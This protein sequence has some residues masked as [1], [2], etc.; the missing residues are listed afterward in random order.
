MEYSYDGSRR[1]DQ[2]ANF[3]PPE[4]GP[5]EIEYLERIGSGCF[6]QVFRGRCRG[7]EVAIKKL[8]RQEIDPKM[9]SEFRKEV[10]I[11]TSLR[12]PNV[13]LL[14]GA[15]L[16]PGKMAL[17]MEMCH[18]GSL[19]SY[20]HDPKNNISMFRRLQMVRDTVLGMNW[21][22]CSQPLI[23]HRDLK[24]ANLLLDDNLH[25]RVCDFGLSAVKEPQDKLQDKDGIRGT[26]LWMAPE[27]LQ[28][29][30]LDEK[31]DVYSFAICLWEIVT[32]KEPFPHMDSFVRFKRA[33]CDKD[34]RPELTPD[35]PDHIQQ[36]LKLSWQKDPSKRPTFKQILEM[37][38]TGMVDYFVADQ[39]ANAFWKEHFSGQ[40]KVSWET[41]AGLFCRLLEIPF[42]KTSKD[43]E[44]IHVK[45]LRFLLAE[46]KAGDQELVVTLENFGHFCSWFSPIERSK[47]T[48]DRIEG[49]VRNN[50]FHGSI[51]KEDSETLLSSQPEGTF[52]IR[53]SSTSP[54]SFTISKKL[55]GRVIHQRI[56][57]KP[58]FGF[59]LKGTKHKQRNIPLRDFIRE[60]SPSLNLKSDCPGSKYSHVFVSNPDD[61][62]GY[63]MDDE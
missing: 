8:T 23:I 60:I 63:L 45:Y 14:M 44:Q 34:E 58:G 55:E 36:I 46:P 53:L 51:T 2:F 42:S 49:I 31:T 39:I 20:L 41:F 61:L 28:G 57:Y 29:K 26:P 40:I 5:D 7:V 22:H 16:T 59:T 12:H 50:W 4:I 6:G 35:I 1:N 33:V 32:G 54:G 18:K 15:C 24:P 62:F 10:E 30:Q 13:L 48:T 38:D 37:L 9:L 3:G 47:A 11:M 21:L 27:V 25:V 43:A 56:E 52:L 17:V 19:S